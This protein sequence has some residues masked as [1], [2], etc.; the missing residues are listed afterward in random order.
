MRRLAASV[1]LTLLFATAAIEAAAEPQEEA[2]PRRYTFSW[3]FQPDDRMQPRGGTTRGP[4]VELAQGSGERWRALNEPGLSKLERDRRA[5]LAMAGG[6]RTT[7][8]FIETIGFTPDYQ[9]APPYQSWATEYVYVIAD[10]PEFISLQHVLAMRFVDDDGNLSEPMV[11][12]HW[13]QDWRY[14]DATLHVYAGHDRWEE[15]RLPPEQVAGTWSQSVFQV[16]DSPRYQAVGRWRH[17]GSHA[18]WTSDRTWRPLPRREF[19]VRDDY[20][21]LAGTNRVTI[22]P[23]GW[24][25]EEDNLKVVLDAQGR[26]DAQTPYLAREAGLNRYQRISGYDFSPADAYWQRTAPFWREVRRAWQ[27][28]FDRREAFT[29]RSRV[30]GEA[31]FQVMFELADRHSGDGEVDTGAARRDIRSVLEQFIQ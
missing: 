15:K 22:T 23:D 1:A 2:E 25:H 17:R 31:L 21:A 6:W 19:S 30:D 16:D 26:P 12:K 29:L 8:D 24:V 4:D 11:V 14:E 10:E 5:I 9:P 18:T 13:R 7:F 28:V 3:P 27:Q 20:D